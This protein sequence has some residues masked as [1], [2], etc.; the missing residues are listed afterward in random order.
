MRGCGRGPSRLANPT[1]EKRP[2]PFTNWT[3]CVKRPGTDP[4]VLHFHPSTRTAVF[5][6][7][8]KIIC[9]GQTPLPPCTLGGSAKQV[10]RPDPERDPGP[11]CP[12]AAVEVQHTPG[13]SAKQVRRPD[14]ERDPERAWSMALSRTTMRTADFA[15]RADACATW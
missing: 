5:L 9:K 3:E 11:P 8:K 6:R 4:C 1:I 14:P 7:W 2:L 12:I 15:S 10:R 13:G